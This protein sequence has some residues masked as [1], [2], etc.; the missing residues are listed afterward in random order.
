MP[1]DKA[2]RRRNLATAA[3]LAAVAVG[4]YVA[5]FISMSG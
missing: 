3:V 4:F 1:E 2:L 5:I